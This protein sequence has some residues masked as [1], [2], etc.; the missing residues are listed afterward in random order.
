MLD[1]AKK[2]LES[3]RRSGRKVSEPV[4]CGKVYDRQEEA[5]VVAVVVLEV[6]RINR[7]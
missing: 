1:E 6:E 2:A 7:S 5:V 4:S 3:G